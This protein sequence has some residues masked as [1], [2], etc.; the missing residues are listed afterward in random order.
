MLLKIFPRSITTAFHG[1]YRLFIKENIMKMPRRIATGMVTASLAMS[2][3]IA[4]AQAQS[5]SHTALATSTGLGSSAVNTVI[6]VGINVA[7]AVA[8]YNFLVQNRI[9]APIIR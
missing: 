4:P 1:A 2:L 9:I 5:L 7:V 8:V 6:G 3:A